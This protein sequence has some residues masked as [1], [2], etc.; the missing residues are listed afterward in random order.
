MALKGGSRHCRPAETSDTASELTAAKTMFLLGNILH[1]AQ[2]NKL[3]IARTFAGPGGAPKR[4]RARWRMFLGVR[5]DA[6][7]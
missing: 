7:S 2:G 6:G 5:N 3:V 1:N 4:R